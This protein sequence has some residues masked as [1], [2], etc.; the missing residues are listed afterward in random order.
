MKEYFKQASRELKKTRSLTGAAIIEAMGPVLD[1]FTIVVNDFLQISFTS[2]TH[3]MTGYLYGPLMGCMAG[4]V[5]DIIKY[6]IKPTGAFFPGF[7]INE[8]LSGFIYGCF[9]YKKE[10][11]L[12]RVIVARICVVFIINL[13]LIPLW[14]SIMYGNAYKFMVA[15]R[16]IKNIVQLPIDVFILYTILKFSEKNI[17]GRIVK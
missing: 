13:V 16:I 8:M 4:G 7:T 10:V 6:L 11:K 12:H 9:F 1:L 15:T 2:L 14:L 17:N 5:A 3:A